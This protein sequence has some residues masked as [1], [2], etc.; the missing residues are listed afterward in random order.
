MGGHRAKGMEGR[1]RDLKQHKAVSGWEPCL[2][3]WEAAVLFWIG[4]CVLQTLS[5][6]LPCGI[7]QHFWRLLK[8]VSRWGNL[9]QNAVVSWPESSSWFSSMLVSGATDA[10]VHWV[11]LVPCVQHRVRAV[12]LMG[13]WP[14][15][16]T[17]VNFTSLRFSIPGLEVWLV[18]WPPPGSSPRNDLC[19]LLLPR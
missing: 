1:R 16:P 18:G 10:T 8:W 7:L 9:T 3:I 11:H 4:T 15:A 5:Q 13:E 6:Q 2:G 14:P 12:V 17:L 19:L